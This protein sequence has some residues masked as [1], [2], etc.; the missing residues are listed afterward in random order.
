MTATPDHNAYFQ[1]FNKCDIFTPDPISQ[2][3]ATKL[4]L[5]NDELSDSRTHSHRSLLDPAVGTGNLLKYIPLHNYEVVD[6]YDIKSEYIE[7]LP[8]NIN[9][10]LGHTHLGHM[11]LGHTHL[12]DFLF[13]NISRKYTNIIL[14]PPYIKHRELPPEYVD[15]LKQQWPLFAKGNIDIYYMFLMK[16]IEL[17]EENGVMVAITPNT[18]LHNK[19]SIPFRRYLFANTLI[20][21]IIDFKETKVF[22]KVA[23]YCCITVITK[24]PKTTFLYNDQEI[25]YDSL[26]DPA[27][28]HSLVHYL[29]T[30]K[31]RKLSDIC[32]IH[33][34]LST[35]RDNVYIHDHPLYDE[36]CWRPLLTIA[37]D[38]YCIFPYNCDGV[39]IEE[40]VFQRENPNTYAYLLSK[41]PELEKRD[42][43]RKTYPKWYSYGRPQSLVLPNVNRAIYMPAFFDPRNLLFRVESPMLHNSSICIVPNNESDIPWIQQ[44]IVDQLSYIQKNSRIKCNGWVNVPITLLKN[45]SI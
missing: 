5:Y 8:E 4:L 19:P 7:S 21:E 43:G 45:L 14:N 16:S 38:K 3:M 26:Q 33:G 39:E 28:T 36:P 31:T 37:K 42:N 17:L 20:R 34:G 12:E 44:I 6:V 40:T 13:A 10:H 1:Q 25:A 15:Q 22:S 24:T 30:T 35:S 11:H 29:P 9:T 41:R 2:I 18:Y 23:I 32:S 27:N